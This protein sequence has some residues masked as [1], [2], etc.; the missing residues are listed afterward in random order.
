VLLGA[1]YGLRSVIGALS[2]CLIADVSA[3]TSAG[4]N[5]TPEGT[6]RA[7]VVATGRLVGTLLIAPPLQAAYGVR[8]TVL[9]NGRHELTLQT[10]RTGRFEVGLPPGRYSLVGRPL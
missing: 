3:C 6:S 5:V 10:Q 9:V 2:L 7:L 8:G 4:G 1:V